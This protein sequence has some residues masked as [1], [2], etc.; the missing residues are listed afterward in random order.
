M[1]YTLSFY[2]QL[3]TDLSEAIAAIR[4][5]YDPTSPFA[6]PHITVLFPVPGSVG[7]RR[8]V[9]HIQNVLSDW[10]PFEIQLGGFHKSRDHWLF[11]TLHEGAAQVKKLYRLLYTG[12]LEDYRS[13]DK[14]FVPHLGLGLFLKEGSIYNWDSPQESAFDRDRYEEAL[15]QAK[16][17]PLA[18]SLSV[19]RLHLTRIPD[20]LLEW[21]TGKRASIPGDSESVEVREFRL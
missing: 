17:L 18:L 19:D 15:G 13:D 11:L 1:Y 9:N 7:E 8:L 4:R 21:A 12:M 14:E 2:P 20:A 3:S 5:E 6:K 10:S 16:E